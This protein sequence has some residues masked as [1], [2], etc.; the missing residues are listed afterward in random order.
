MRQGRSVAGVI[1][2]SGSTRTRRLA[3]V[4]VPFVVAVL[5]SGCATKRDIRDMRT[6]LRRLEARQDSIFRLLQMQNREILDSL[7]VTTEQLLNVRGELA[8]QLTTLQD[9]LVQVG[10]LTGQVQIRLNQLD[11][12]L[13]SAVRDVSAA[14]PGAGAP[15]GGGAPGGESSGAREYYDIGLEQLERGNAETARRAFETVVEQ[16]PSDPLAAE[17]QRQIGE[18]YVLERSYDDAL[19]AFERVVQR[20]QDSQAAP[21]ALYR[22]G[23]VAQAQG[24]PERARQ[25]FQR[26]ISAYPDSDARRL[27]ENALEGM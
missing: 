12:Q 11:Q 13:A 21:L 27:A 17:A 25:Y 20:Y 26:V 18:T 3:R 10:E 24:S 23:V 7:Q 22:A 4:V 5:A 15:E 14:V 16:Y 9:Q 6:D 19:E 8:S 1:G 2:G